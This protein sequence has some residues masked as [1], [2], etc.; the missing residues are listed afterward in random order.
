M[1]EPHEYEFSAQLGMSNGVAAG[2]SVG[3]ILLD[4]IPGATGVRRA[5]KTD[6]RQ[7]TDW[8]VERENGRRLS[9]D[10]KVRRDDYA[11]RGKDDLALETWSVMEHQK[12]GWSRDSGKR[13]DYILW[14]WESTG[15]WCLIPF[16]LLCAVFSGLWMEWSEEY[17]PPARQRTRAD[18]VRSDEDYHSECVFV[19]RRVV[20]G[21]IYR[22][23]G[24]GARGEGRPRPRY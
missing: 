18:G 1:T 20:W 15:R 3:T 17:G 16:P 4:N 8:W 13:T 6:D 7:G 10:C 11:P 5:D 2:R 14:L 22:M 9:V 24:G 21:A 12:I 19:P 23:F